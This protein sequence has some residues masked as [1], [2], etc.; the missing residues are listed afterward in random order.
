MTDTELD[1]GDVVEVIYD[2]ENG[3]ELMYIGV[4]TGFGVLGVEVKEVYRVSSEDVLHGVKTDEW[5]LNKIGTGY[6]KNTNEILT[7]NNWVPITEIV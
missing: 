2:T 7:E 3:S 4:V 5:S 6:N 1:I